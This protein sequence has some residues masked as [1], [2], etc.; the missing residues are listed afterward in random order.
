MLAIVTDHKDKVRTIIE[1]KTQANCKTNNRNKLLTVNNKHT[2][3]R[4]TIKPRRVSTISSSKQNTSKSFEFKG[5]A[6]NNRLLQNR[7]DAKSIAKI[8]NNNL[9]YSNTNKYQEET[10]TIQS[11]INQTNNNYINKHEGDK[12]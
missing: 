2:L 4:R 8:D 7:I 3:Q 12:L 5:K 6:H 10:N 9:N 1:L 11:E